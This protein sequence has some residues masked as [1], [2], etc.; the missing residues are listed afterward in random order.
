M[1][2]QNG[3]VANADEVLNNLAGTQF[4]NFSQLLFNSD[5]IGFQ[6]GLGC[7]T[8]SPILKNVYY[9]TT[10]TNNATSA[11][12]MIWDGS[13]YKT[14][15]VSAITYYAIIEASAYSGSH[16]NVIRISSGKWLVYTTTSGETGRALVMQY[17]LGSRGV[18]GE[19]SKF[20]SCT[21][22]KMSDANDAGMRGYRFYCQ[23][24]STTSTSCSLT[25]ND[26]T[27]NTVSSWSD[28]SSDNGSQPHQGTWEC[29][30][31]NV[32]HI[33][34]V[35]GGSEST[36]NEIGTDLSADEQTNP[37]NGRL[38][39]NSGSNMSAGSGTYVIVWCQG[40][41]TRSGSGTMVDYYTDYGI[42]E[43]TTADTLVNEGVTNYTLEFI[44]GVIGK[45]QDCIPSW[46]S[47]ISG[48]TTLSVFA[49]TSG[50]A[51]YE[52]IYNGSITRFGTT[53][54]YFNIKF[55]GSRSDTTAIDYIA[56]WASLY[57]IGAT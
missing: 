14:L 19:L 53:G 56:D 38:G 57:N 22:I 48:T 31:G 51:N 8:G 35:G 42:P 54:S 6:S 50:T 39:F 2:I 45:I 5:R 37:A 16:S 40:S 15:N 23:S 20:T 11:Y 10:K 29:P 24:G 49:C 47:V 3:Q 7:S 30:T 17:L 41:I 25:F 26:T 1:T 18:L 44:S 4:R 34:A 28:V 36:E 46:N 27:G 13:S 55:I 52:Q 12:N 21:A 9:R 43:S 32:L 33:V